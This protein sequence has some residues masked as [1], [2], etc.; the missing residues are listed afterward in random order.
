MSLRLKTGFA[1]VLEYMSTWLRKIWEGIAR[2]MVLRPKRV[3]FAALC[4]RETDDGKEVLLI[5]SRDSGRWIIPKGWPI[6]GKEGAETALQEAWEEAGVRPERYEREALGQ[7]TYDKIL[8]DGT[9]QQ[10]QTNV[11]YVAVK[12]LADQ[13]PEAGERQR[14]WVSP[15]IAAERVQEPGLST[16]L[17]SL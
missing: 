17:L 16:L 12:E 3:Q 2:P 9:A 1:R 8:K 15:D 10:V 4:V 11:Y 7:F 5:T 6:D 14:S 13:Y